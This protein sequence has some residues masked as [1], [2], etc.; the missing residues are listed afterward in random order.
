MGQ[1]VSQSIMG[2]DVER[3]R[4]SKQLGINNQQPSARARSSL[5]AKKTSTRPE[6]LARRT[7][8]LRRW[9]EENPEKFEMIVTRFITTRISRP[10]KDLH[11]L[12]QGFDLRRQVSIQHPSC[13]TKSKKLRVDI[14]CLK[15]KIL[16]EF[17]GPFHFRSIMGIDHL[18]HRRAR[19]K[20]LEAYAVEN[21]MT[22]I[23]IAQS[24]YVKG[25]FLDACI[26][27]VFA[28]L[29]HPTPGIY[30]F[31][32]EYFNGEDN[33]RPHATAGYDQHGH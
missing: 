31:G 2:N 11:C 14:G 32:E 30:Y 26:Q 20:S 18:E 5:V 9:R 8:N 19:D 12:L 33:D 6:I 23:R 28:I 16:I 1:A 4:R 27:K 21:D 24:Q 29:E 22:L 7:E 17:D 10:E 25:E 3:L 13:P 15:R